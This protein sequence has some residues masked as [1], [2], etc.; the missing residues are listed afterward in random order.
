MQAQKQVIPLT[1]AIFAMTA[2]GVGCSTYQEQTQSMTQKWQAGNARGAA[3]EF[4]QKAEK[5]KNKK[6][7]IIWRLEQAAALRAA[8]QY[9]E[10]NNAFE[11]AEERI[12]KYDASAK[13]K[14]GH[15][16]A[17]TL[18]NQANL[19]YEGRIYDK[20]MLSTYKAMNDLQLG[21]YEKARVDLNRVLRW[22]E[23][24]VALNA[25]RLE[26][27]QAADKDREKTERAEQDAKFKSQLDGAYGKL[28]N[29]KSY[30]DYVNPFSVYLDALYFMNTA[31]G[32][33][34]LERAN[35]SLERVATFMPD[36]RF[37]KQD[38]ETIKQLFEGKPITPLTYV[39]FETGS[40]PVRGEIRIDIPIIV[41]S[42]SYIGA[43]FPTL[44]YVYNNVP[45]LTVTANGS[46]QQ[47]E[48]VG[49]MDSVIAQDFKN[50]LPIIITKTLISTITKGAAAY[51]VNEAANQQDSALGLFSQITTAITQAALNIADLR[52]WTTLPKEFQVCRVATP[53]DRKIEVS[54][55]GQ[56]I[57]VTVGE[58]LVNLVFVKSINAQSPLLV[59]QAKLR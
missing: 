14:I 49:S 41:T 4:G 25:A 23:D 56:K 37:V 27:A 24:A 44:E 59:S 7:A 45:S 34:D 39:I 9:K 22:Q 42:V 55:G 31:A 21:D 28:D 20:I 53:S 58:G 6:D 17:A 35:K 13:V 1:F 2:F 26:K 47:T 15:E 48:L 43:A 54:A 8:Q 18:S 11:Q 36:N 46:S 19:P 29:I 33:S 52:T 51:V 12:L 10:S 32:S 5:E 3:E 57:P 50:E 16:A 40:A 38:Q 30:G